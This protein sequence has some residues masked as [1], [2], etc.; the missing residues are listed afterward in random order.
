MSMRQELRQMP[1]QAGR[2]G[3]TRGEAASMPVSDEACC[4]RHESGDTGSALLMAALTRAN[5]KQAFKRV[6]ANKGA[7]GVDGLDIDQ[8]SRHLVTAW[9]AIREQLLKGTYRPSPVRR[10]TIPKPDGGERELGIPTV[11]DRLIQQALL[12]VLQPVLDPTFSEHSYGF[13]P[14][15]RAHDAVL[16]AQSYVQSGRRIVVDVDLEKFFDRINHDILIDR[17]QK[18]IGDAGVIRLIRAYLN[19]GIMD[20]GVVQQR[21]QG[22]PQGGPLSPLLANVLLDEVDKELERRG[23][24][25][26][27]YADDANVY[28]RSRRA[29]ERVMVLL[30]RLFG[31]LRLKVNETKSA[32]ASVFGRKFLG[33]S[34][35]VASGGVIK[36]KVAAKP[37]LAFKRRIRELTG[38]NGGRS[39]KDVVE[40]L[41]PY[42]L[43]WRA[44]F[45]LAQTPRV[46]R[47]LDEW[48]RHRLRVIQLKQWRRGPTI[49]RELRAL[50]APHAVAQQVAANSRRWWRNSGKLLNSVLTLAYFERLGA[51]RLS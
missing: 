12:Q 34:L 29:G 48:V 16:A 27:R 26:V 28:V 18:R 8:T 19:S 44:Y 45:R 36:R 46:W 39:M 15:R 2:A 23:H 31:R 51:P 41:R 30:R 5:L 25:F 38:R 7:A 22:T 32:V 4:P 3:G 37:L 24:C 17:L 1:A 14:G 20:G 47:T 43:G 10:V 11:T 6:R 35:W 49:Y 42:V 40:R 33:Y 50:G 9:P 13:R 21:E